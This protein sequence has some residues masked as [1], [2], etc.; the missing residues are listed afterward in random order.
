MK[1]F[2]TIIMLLVSSMGLSA[3]DNLGPIKWM[4]FEEAEKLDSAEHRPFLIDVYTDWCGWCK[5]MMAT[6]FQNKQLAAYINKNFY[7]IRFDAETNDTIKFMGKTW[8]SD[9]RV[10]S[11]AV[12]LL[13]QRLSYPTIVYFDRQKNKMPVPGFMAEKDI[14]PILV[15]FAEDLT[16]YANIETFRNLYMCSFPDVYS[17]DLARLKKN[18]KDTVGNIKWMTMQEMNDKYAKEPKPILVDIYV[19][20]KYRGYVPYITMNSIVHERA[21]LHNS[22]ICDY[23]NEH[24]YPVRVEATTTDTLY[25]FGQGPFVSTGNGMPNQ[26]T[27]A[28]MRGNYK[29]PAMFFFDKEHNFVSNVSVFFTPD[30][31]T[32]VLSFYAEEAYKNESFEKYYKRKIHN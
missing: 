18:D 17:E 26:F 27:N 7:C 14:E 21:V 12:Y 1:K 16:D 2:F 6:T 11:L 15:Y 22:T 28:L 19:D 10:N 9:G 30:I 3:Q 32:H 20:D 29:F 13:D 31:W 4:T 24:Y 25:W 23:I 8:T 5:R